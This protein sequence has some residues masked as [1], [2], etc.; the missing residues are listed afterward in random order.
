MLGIAAQA[1][2]DKKVDPVGTWTWSTPGR[3]GGPSRTNTLKLKLEG[4]KLAGTVSGRQSDTAI[5]D[6]KLTGDEITFKVTLERGGNTFTQKYAGKISGDTIKGKIEFDRQ[7]E[8][9]SR[10]WVAKR[11]T[12]KPKEPAK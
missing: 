3:D 8:T 12:S 7:G 6:A 1:A 9:Q 10:E 5:A 2:D 11:E 4:G